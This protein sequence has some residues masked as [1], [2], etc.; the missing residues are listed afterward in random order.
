MPSDARSIKQRAH[1]SVAAFVLTFLLLG[2][3]G[4]LVYA[5][6]RLLLACLGVL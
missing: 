6:A 4:S 3:V 5:A 1:A 2:G